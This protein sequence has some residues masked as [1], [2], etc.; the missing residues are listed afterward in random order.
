MAITHNGTRNSL[1]NNAIP[2]GYTRPTVTTFDDYEYTRTV[3]LNVLK[4][5]VESATASTTMTNIFDNATIGLN[6]QVEDILAGDYL[7]TATVTAWSDLV[8]LTHNLASI[9]G[10]GE[11]LKNTAMQYVCT[12]KIYI[13]TA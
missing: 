10:A 4:S 12:V 11:Y 8:D 13:K 1:G 3:K 6:K 9:Q 5:T 2:V 7:A